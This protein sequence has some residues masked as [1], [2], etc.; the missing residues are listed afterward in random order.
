MTSLLKTQVPRPASS[1]RA[2][3]GWVVERRRGQE[4][5]WNSGA[6]PANVVRT[7]LLL[8][9]RQDENTMRERVRFSPIKKI[10]ARHHLRF[11]P[12]LRSSQKAFNREVR[13]E[14]PRRSQRRHR[15]L[16]FACLA[17]FLCG[18]SG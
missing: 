2:G 15:R 6:E 16:F 9:C 10:Y 14:R 5:R 13:E 17:D 3:I 7:I 11:L 18:I 12:V 8:R 1:A 4:V